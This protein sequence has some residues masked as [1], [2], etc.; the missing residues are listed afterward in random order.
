VHRLVSSSNQELAQVLLPEDTYQASRDNQTYDHRIVRFG[1]VE[2]QVTLN[3]EA[4][5][6]INSLVN[7]AP[8]KGGYF[9]SAPQ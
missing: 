5:T 2:G 4:N 9:S 6:F 8:Q 3:L 7:I 1:A